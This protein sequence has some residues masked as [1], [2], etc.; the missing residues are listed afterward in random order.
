M[1]KSLW[2]S[3]KNGETQQST[4]QPGDSPDLSPKQ[5]TENIL[6]GVTLTDKD[7]KPFNNTDNRPNPNSITKIDFT[8]EVLK[9]LNVK[10]R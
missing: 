9:S 5:I 4:E 3:K 2:K 10:K 1:L 6:T 7:G 8:W